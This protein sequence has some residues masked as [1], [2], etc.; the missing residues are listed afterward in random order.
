MTRI[1]DGARGAV[2][3]G[4]KEG[5]RR[6]GGGVPALSE[7]IVADE[8]SDR[9]GGVVLPRRRHIRRRFVRRESRRLEGGSRP[10]RLRQQR[11][12]HRRAALD[13]SQRGG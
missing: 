11:H 10:E 9:V 8:A 13:R 3:G 12:G 1:L 7:A 4:D 5:V 2:G 6:D